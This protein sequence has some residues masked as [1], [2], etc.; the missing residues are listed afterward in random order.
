M[1]SPLLPQPDETIHSFIFRLCAIYGVEH[2]SDVINKKGEWAS[3]LQLNK[4]VRHYFLSL[5]DQQIVDLMQNCGWANKKLG[6]FDDPT[7]YMSIIDK[8]INKR[9][10]NHKRTY[11][12]PIKYCI[13]CIKDS[14]VKNGYG[15]FKSDWQ[16]EY[17]N[18]CNV[19]R[20]ALI[21]IS[22]HTKF[23]SIQDLKQIF[24]GILPKASYCELYYNPKSIT[25]DVKHP[26]YSNISS[27]L[28]PDQ[29]GN[30]LQISSCLKKNIKKWL[31][32]DKYDFPTAVAR[33]AHYSSPTSMKPINRNHVFRDYV[34]IKVI[35]ALFATRFEP[36]M[37]FW[38]EFAVKHHVYCGVLNKKDI[39]E[40]IYIYESSKNCQRCYDFR[41]PANL[42]I[43]Y[44]HNHRTLASQCFND[45]QK[46][47]KHLQKRHNIHYASRNDIRKLTLENKIKVLSKECI[48]CCSSDF[49]L[50]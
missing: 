4:S 42:S 15:Y 46:L 30:F 7:S 6:L 13:H 10:A 49:G 22:C 48:D 33:A 35:I 11:N 29:N 47:A 28:L 17:G 32:S 31:I 23:Q 25:W 44:F 5:H 2:L 50:L 12:L 36:F 26:Y 45:Y 24:K 41:C 43:K 39:L 38:S 9:K 37:M 20:E 16:L 19:H 14:I 18:F 27:H 1:T 21:Y 3:S 40:N 8:L 34:L